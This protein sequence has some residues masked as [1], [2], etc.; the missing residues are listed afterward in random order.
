MSDAI[1]EDVKADVAI[2]QTGDHQLALRQL[3]KM[4]SERQRQL[5]SQYSWLVPPTADAQAAGVFVNPERFA[6]SVSA[7]CACGGRTTR[8]GGRDIGGD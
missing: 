8:C 5:D 3:N 7:V 1:S 2:W 4:L 6:T